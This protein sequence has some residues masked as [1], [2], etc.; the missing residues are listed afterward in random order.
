LFWGA[1]SE[2]Q[3]SPYKAVTTGQFRNE[4]FAPV[5]RLAGSPKLDLLAGPQHAD[6][7]A[8]DTVLVRF[9]T[10]CD[11]VDI[12]IARHCCHRFLRRGRR[13]RGCFEALELGEGVPTRGRLGGRLVIRESVFD[14]VVITHCAGVLAS[15]TAVPIDVEVDR[16]APTL[17]VNARW[18]CEPLSR[19]ATAVPVADLPVASNSTRAPFD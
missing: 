18:F 1:C 8:S 4:D 7:D 19:I 16:A 9:V 3:V 11:V 15:S 14:E 13:R 6:Y 17:A 5:I 2:L 12:D 10:L